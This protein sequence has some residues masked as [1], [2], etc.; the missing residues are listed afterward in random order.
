MSKKNKNPWARATGAASQIFAYLKSKQVVTRPQ[1]LD[2]AMNELGLNEKQAMGQ[3]A[4][5][6]SPRH[7]DQCKGDPRGSVSAKG[8]LYYIEPLPKKARG[9]QKR[10]RLRWRETPLE[11]K[12]ATPKTEAVKATKT[13]KSVSTKE[14]ETA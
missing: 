12:Q 13:R 10:F 11:Q 14:A 1:L 4:C 2:Y 7:P 3:I 5:V 6:L 8:H 9:D